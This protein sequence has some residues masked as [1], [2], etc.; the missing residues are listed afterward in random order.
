MSS[1]GRNLWTRLRKLEETVPTKV[2]GR[3]SVCGGDREGL[4]GLLILQ[5]GI[6]IDHFQRRHCLLSSLWDPESDLHS[7]EPS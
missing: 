5:E 1:W 7:F 6:Q 4:Y 2:S 3:C